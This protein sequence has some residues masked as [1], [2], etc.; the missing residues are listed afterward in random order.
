MYLSSQGLT[1]TKMN[2][3]GSI[4]YLGC[5]QY[6]LGRIITVGKGLYNLLGFRSV[7]YI[8]LWP[9]KIC[10]L[11][12]HLSKNLLIYALGGFGG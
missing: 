10:I 1:L 4:L 9:T 8:I 7:V 3:K 6:A 11:P 2:E 12:P 5:D